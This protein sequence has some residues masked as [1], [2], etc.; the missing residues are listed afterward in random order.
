M[1]NA[2]RYVATAL[3]SVLATS[4]PIEVLVI[5]DQSADRSREVVGAIAD[6]RIKI[7]DGP[8]GGISD[9]LNVGLRNA[10]GSIL[11]RCDADDIYPPNRIEQQVKWLEDHPEF[12]ALCGLFSTIDG[13]DREVVKMLSGDAA[14]E[15]TGE[16]RTGEV[17]TH[18]CTFAIRSAVAKRLEFRSFFKTA[19]DV[20]YQLRLGEICRVFYQPV[21]RYR[22]RIH[23]TSITHTQATNQREF[24]RTTA[25]ACQLQRLKGDLD[26]VASGDATS[27]MLPEVADHPDSA[28]QHLQGLLL[29]KAWAEYANG[30]RITAIGYN[31]K[32]IR[33]R[34]LDL[35]SWK[36]M[37][38]L[39][40]RSIA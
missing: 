27:D 38:A 32:A 39:L 6:D 36:S 19:E 8:A 18:L 40:W 34:P 25:V 17:R 23:S 28:A 14:C 33:Y 20:D 3:R 30:S 12:D 4:V 13:N 15:L 5:D 10:S 21:E 1:R 22:Y 26:I 35:Q 2:E 9:C 7:L 16:L 29:G 11:M 31:L 24:F 37:A